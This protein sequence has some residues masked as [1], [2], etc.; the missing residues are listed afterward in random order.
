MPVVHAAETDEATTMDKLAESR[1]TV[2]IGDADVRNYLAVETGRDRLNAMFSKSGKNTAHPELAM[3]VTSMTQCGIMM[4]LVGWY[5]GGKMGKERFLEKS[6]HRKF[7][8]K[9]MA[10]RGMND[11]MFIG[12]IKHAT[13]WGLKTATFVG[14]FMVVSQSIAVYRNKSS[15]LEYVAGGAVTGSLFRLNMGL[16][17]VVGGGSVGGTLGL[18]GGII[19]YGLLYMSGEMAEQRHYWRVHEHLREAKERH[20]LVFGKDEE[21]RKEAGNTA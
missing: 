1:P 2:V 14:I 4:S 19:V 18:L 7:D 21:E 5:I 16:K 12:A 8:T 3:V 15:V 20:L 6:K 10:I 11:A 9:F 17:G 13:K